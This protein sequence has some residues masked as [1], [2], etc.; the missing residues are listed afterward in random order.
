MIIASSQQDDKM[1][2]NFIFGFS[3]FLEK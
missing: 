2:K 1:K 3:T